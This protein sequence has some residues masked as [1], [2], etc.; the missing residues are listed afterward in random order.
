[1]NHGI[2]VQKAHFHHFQSLVSGYSPVKLYKDL[3]IHFEIT[4]IFFT[5]TFN[6][7]LCFIFHFQNGIAKNLFINLIHGNAAGSGN[8]LIRIYKVFLQ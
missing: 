5:V 3:L 1:M 8:V 2:L 6:I 7:V 4:D